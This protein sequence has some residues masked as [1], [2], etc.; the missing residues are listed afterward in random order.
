M[1]K[2]KITKAMMFATALVVFISSCR[3]KDAV[4]APDVL[5]NFET[6]AQGITASENSITIKIKLSAAA[7]AAIPVIL[8][9]TETAVAYTTDYTTNPAVAGGKI[10]LTVPSGSNEASFTLTKKAGRPFDGDEKIVFEI[11]STGTPVIIGGT[12][13]LTLTFAELVAVTT[14]QTANG[15]GATYPNKVFIDISAERQAAVNRTT[16]D[17]GFYS[18]GADFNV[19]LN[20]AVGMMAKQINKTDLNAVTAADTIGFGA[21][22]I[23]NQNTPTTTS[24]AYIDYP[25]GDLSKTAIKPVSATA[26]DNKVY[27]INMGKGVA[28]NTTALAPDRGWKKVRVIRN[29]TGGYTLQHADI[30]A[31]TFTSV[32]IAKD[33]NYHFKYAS[34]QTGAINIEPEKNKWDIAWTYFSNVTNF[35]S[36]EVPYLFQDII[37]LNRGVSVAK[38]MI[39]AGT[40]YENFA[41]ANITSSLP[42]LTAQNAIAADWRAGGGPGVAPSVR[43]D[44]FYVIKDA[45]GNYYKLKFTSLTNT[46]PPAPPE[47]GNPAYE[48]TWLKKD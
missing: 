42:F 35:G 1:M 33:A 24:L 21:D 16:W 41:A 26:N 19:I 29:T 39:A 4:S 20:S 30:A 47:R 12:K 7:S 22:V 5:A 31:T 45:D 9:V 37:L 14:T 25:D 38:V 28:A 17:L 2:M 3:D 27:I 15:G 34:F 48:A 44:R 13:Q 43:T 8:N 36:G 46:T 18:S 10:S 11:F 23:F 6:A 40:T 32:D